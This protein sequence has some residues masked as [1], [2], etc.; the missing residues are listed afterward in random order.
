LKQVT[1]IFEPI[2]LSLQ[3]STGQSI[4]EA[5]LK[6]H[7]PIGGE[8]GGVGKCGKCQVII[9]QQQSVSPISR[10]EQDILTKDEITAGRRL[11]CQA[12][13][14]DDLSVYIPPDI[15]GESRR[16]QVDSVDKFITPNPMIRK[17][18]IHLQKPHLK[19]LRADF[20]R[21]VDG[22]DYFQNL[23]MNLD[24]LTKIPKLL[25]DSNWIVSV[26]LWDNKKIIAI[27]PED[28]TLDC[29]GLAVDI[30]S[31][32]IVVQ[33]INLNTGETVATHGAE[34]PQ[35]MYGEDV[36]E[37]IR[38]SEEKGMLKH[39]QKIVVQEINNLLNMMTEETGVNPTNIYEMVVVGNTVMNHIFLGVSPRNIAFS[40][41]TPVF[42]SPFNAEVSDIGL[43]INPNGMIHIP[44]NIAGFVGADA[45]ADM[46]ASGILETEKLMLQLDIGTNTEVFLGNRD[47]VATCSCASGPAFEG[48]HI[49]HGMKAV[50]GA[51]ERVKIGRDI[52]VAYGTIGDSDPMGLCGS[53][54][55]DLVAE[56]FRHDIMDSKGKI[57]RDLDTERLRIDGKLPEFVVAWQEETAIEKDIVLTQKDV[58][59]ILL[60]KAAIFTG[61][62]VLMKR[63]DIHR[64]QIEEVVI[65]GAFGSYLNPRNT[66]RIGMIPDMDPQIISFRGNLALLG[67]KML[68][69]SS[70]YREIE[71]EI[72]SKINY[73][74]LTTDPDFSSEYTNALFLP[75][76]I[77][78]RFP[79]LQR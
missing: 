70:K 47:G 28:T 35:L 62:S 32:K 29:Y 7:V 26:V 17:L 3:V 48:A 5:A 57:R 22:V 71:K 20:E 50:D 41:F 31:S 44:T 38:I 54:V 64:E 73:V 46:I 56:L 24:V 52:A 2:G 74:E 60:A 75:N 72:R 36:V 58:N 11:A 55:V 25:R 27:E 76:R 19:D 15:S 39:L 37:R 18:A 34:N 61:C 68:L 6:A 53:A 23:E 16:I 30:G 69:V 65:G 8:C 14:I 12:K 49:K 4:Y 79:S 13:I 59:E 51:I 33:L 78:E 10:V 21:L 77:L 1:I 40:P 9:E 43:N 66:I 45:T 42:S 67:A 63:M